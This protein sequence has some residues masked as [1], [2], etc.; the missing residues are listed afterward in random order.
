M[1]ELSTISILILN[2]IVTEMPKL[3]LIIIQKTFWLP[4]S[5][6][7]PTNQNQL[8]QKMSFSKLF[9]NFTFSL[10]FNQQNNKLNRQKMMIKVLPGSYPQRKLN[11]F[12]PFSS[13]FFHFSSSHRH[14]WKPVSCAITLTFYYMQFSKT[15][16]LC[17]GGSLVVDKPG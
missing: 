6:R 8:F 16:Q 9:H 4:C 15:P 10:S 2:S 14:L 3:I 11:L 12:S 5:L 17:G 1:I 7:H 13:P